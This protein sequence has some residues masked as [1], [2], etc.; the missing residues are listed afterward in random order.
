LLQEIPIEFVVSRLKIKDKADLAAVADENGFV[1]LFKTYPKFQMIKGKSFG[2][3]YLFERAK[4]SFETIWV[5]RNQ[6]TQYKNKIDAGFGWAFWFP[7]N[8]AVVQ[9]F[10]DFLIFER[11]SDRI[12]GL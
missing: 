7:D 9:I 12:G 10:G 2:F 4:I 8:L 3:F 5:T 1:K 6:E 11:F